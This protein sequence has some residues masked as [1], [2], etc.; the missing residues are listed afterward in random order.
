MKLKQ[1]LKERL[2]KK[3]LSFVPSSF[4]IIGNIAVFNDFPKELRKKEKSIAQAL[5]V[6]H[7]HIKTVAKKTGKFSGKLRTPKMTI[8]AG[9]KTKE[10][11]HKENGCLLKLDIERCYFSPRLASERLRIAK[12]V[13]KGEDV[14]V[15][16]S[17][18]APYPCVIARNACPKEVY[19]IELNKTAHHYAEEN[20]KL[21]KF[22]S[23]HLFQGDIKRVLPKLSK[24]FDRIIMPL[25]KESPAYLSLALKKLKQKGIMHL[26]L[27]AREEDFN[28][29][30]KEYYKKFKHVVLVACGLY[31]PYVYRICL[32][33]SL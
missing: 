17:G 15:L 10:T 18:V 32:D 33:I 13:K 31:A 5:M 12:L 24:K 28:S 20:I 2:T 25:P 8:M 9:K 26:Y 6:L 22:T 4:D 16:F 14:L 7:P 3:E 29:I 21:N 1:A 27:F 11:I 19:G 23:I 30:K